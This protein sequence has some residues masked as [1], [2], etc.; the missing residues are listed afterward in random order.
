MD[1]GS[2][3]G[4]ESHLDGTEY[5]LFVV[6]QHQGKDIH[7][8]PVTPGPLEQMALQLPEGVGQV[9]KGCSVAQSTGLSLRVS[10][11]RGQLFQ[12]MMGTYF[13]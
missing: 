1:L 9:G 4:I 13:A 5:G 8:L 7:H 11:D 2:D 12:R 6:L 10:R 3:A